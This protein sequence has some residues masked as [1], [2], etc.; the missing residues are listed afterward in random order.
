MVSRGVRNENVTATGVPIVLSLRTAAR[1]VFALM[2]LTMKTKFGRS[3]WN[4]VV[5]IGWPLAHLC[6]LVIAFTFVNRMLPFGTESA[7][8]I[9]TGALPYILCVYPAR[10]ASQVFM[11]SKTALFFPIVLPIHL[12]LSRVILEALTACVVC[13]IFCLGLWLLDF[14][15]APNSI[16]TA[17]CSLYA[18]I[19]LGISLGV[20]MAIAAAL[21]GL[22][23]YF[24]F[25][26]LLVVLYMTAGVTVP[27]TLNQNEFFTELRSF[28]PIYHLV[29]WTRSAFYEDMYSPIPLSRSYIILLSG[30]LFLFGFL[31]ERLFRG[32]I[33]R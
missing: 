16:T 17:I 3:Y 31:G 1:V 23:G 26:G 22:P 10:Q 13:I 19:L 24:A 30:G 14:D 2:L 18:A 32:K 33:L 7:V 28:N 12:I 4:Y 5:A 27:I 9:A 8:Y 11:L 6:I 25:I 21:F 20:T 15:I 29:Q